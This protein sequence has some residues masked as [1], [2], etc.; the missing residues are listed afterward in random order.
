MAWRLLVLVFAALPCASLA[1]PEPNLFELPWEERTPFLS[2]ISTQLQDEALALE[3][4]PVYHLRWTLTPLE[5]LQARQEVRV[6]N[7]SGQPWNELWF[8][9]LPNLLGAE[10][11][12]SDPR[13][14]G[15]PVDVYFSNDDG[16]LRVDLTSPVEDGQAVVVGVD[17]VLEIPIASRRNYGIIGF[18][19]E[20]LSLAHAYPL[21][22]V[23]G[24]DG[25]DLDVPPHYGDLVHAESAFFRVSVAAPSDV[26][27]V[28]SGRQLKRRVEGDVQHLE[29]V[30]GPV[31]DFYLAGSFEA[32]LVEARAGN[33]LVRGHA[34]GEAREA[35]AEAVSH[36]V[37]ALEIFERRFG[38]YPYREL[39]IVAISTSALGVEFPGLI[40]LRKQLLEPGERERWLESTTV[41]EVAHQWF[42][43]LVGND[44]VSEPW[45]DE[46]TTQYLTLRYF[47][48][49]YGAEGYREFR[50]SLL[51]RW[52]DVDRRKVPIGLPVE[53]YT[54]REYG[55]V[56]YGLGPLVL[57]WL[58][59]RLSRPGFDEFIRDYVSRYAFRLARSEDFQMLAESHCSCELTSFFQ[60]WVRPTLE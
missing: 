4:A 22:A 58:A 49:R 19:E 30:A 16:L 10:L 39:D 56:V 53:S 13:V 38:A 41:H 50:E 20:F 6:V 18:D 25:W 37:H 2:D 51:S 42:Y 11:R 15:S 17:Y 57:E 23:F 48:D 9:L 59:G 26:A 29:I 55:A 27:L 54:L 28:S 33:V 1:V 32:E 45:L 36:A 35:M 24:E 5:R 46:S 43:A 14:D 40:A 21:L 44:Q 34:P 7:R 52:Q 60:E 12:I 8:H 31:R 47:L 3:G